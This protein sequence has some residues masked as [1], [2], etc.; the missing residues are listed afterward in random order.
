MAKKTLRKPLYRSRVD[1]KIAGVCGGLAVYFNLD[2]TSVRMIFI[3][4]LLVGGSAI[5]LYLL[6]WLI[7]P[8]A[9]LKRRRSQA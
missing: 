9:P 2:S 6:L 3:L 1:K 5:L 7:V 4:L 8:L